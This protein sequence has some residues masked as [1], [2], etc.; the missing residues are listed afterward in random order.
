V[1]ECEATYAPDRELSTHVR[2]FYAMV[3]DVSEQKFRSADE[4]HAS[5]LRVEPPVEALSW[6]GTVNRH[7]TLTSIRQ[8]RLTNPDVL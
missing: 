8:P 1:R 6:G 7:P 4:T 5:T 3:R 2:G